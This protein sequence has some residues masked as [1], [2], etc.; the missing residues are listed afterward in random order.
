MSKVDTLKQQLEP[1]AFYSKVLN[2]SIGKATGKCWYVWNGLCPFHADKHAGSF[3]INVQTGAFKCFSCGVSGGDVIAFHQK[4]SGLAFIDAVND[5]HGRFC[6][7][8]R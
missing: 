1:L 7:E 3:C 5:L 8:S 4:H 2:G 6:H